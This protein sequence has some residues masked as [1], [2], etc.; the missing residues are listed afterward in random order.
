M[1][2]QDALELEIGF[3]PCP[4]DT[5]IFD[6]LIH[7]RIDTAPFRF[8]PRIADVEELNERG[9]AGGGTY[10]LT[11]LSFYAYLLLKDRYC[12]LDS[13]AALGYGCGPLLVA[14]KGG[15]V[16]P[17]SPETGIV[18]PAWIRDARIAVPGRYTTAYLLLQ[19]WQGGCG[20]TE[21][22][23]FDEILPG[24]ASGRYDAG[25]VIHEGRFVYQDYDCRKLVDLGQWWE[26]ETGLPL[27]LGCIALRRDVSRHKE[28]VE[29]LLRQS[30]DHARRNPR[31]GIEFIKLHA[32][33]LDEKVISAHISLYVNQFTFSLGETGMRAVETLEE[34]ARC[35]GI[36]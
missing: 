16:G 31:A 18:S 26:A 35:L 15:G 23:R 4:N 13:G 28:A 32:Q 3:S 22:V 21:F 20:N 9:F 5:F 29:A 27:P 7:R 11:K 14:R 33:E 36:L 8:R 17:I 30:V 24:V 19:L 34:R 2:S 1:S 12:L 25:L 10:P 6:A